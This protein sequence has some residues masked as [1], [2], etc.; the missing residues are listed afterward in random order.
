MSEQP[1]R[2]PRPAPQLPEVQPRLGRLL[3]PAWLRAWWPAVLWACFIFVMSTDSFSAEHTGS[4]IQPI[5]RW[6]FPSITADQFDFIHHI[7]R[8]S[9]HFTE[10]FVFCLLLFRAVRGR[11][12]GSPGSGIPTTT[13][14]TQRIT[15]SPRAT[16]QSSRRSPEP[17][18]E[19]RISWMSSRE[20]RR[21]SPTP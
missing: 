20:R 3:I 6:F 10:Y 12:R 7:I 15:A 19:H 9:A 11:R 18:R 21:P 8:K 13:A 1:W 14:P 4:I 16:C 5:L 2:N 17:W